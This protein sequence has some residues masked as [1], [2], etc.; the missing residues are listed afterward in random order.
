MVRKECGSWD[1]NHGGEKYGC[2]SEMLIYYSEMM[3]GFET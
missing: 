3:K 2:N 1:T